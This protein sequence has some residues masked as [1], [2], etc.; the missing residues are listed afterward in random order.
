VAFQNKKNKCPPGGSKL[1]EIRPSKHSLSILLAE[2]SHMD[3]RLMLLMLKTLGYY[4][5]TAATGIEALSALERQAYDL[6]LMDIQMPEMD[7][8]EATKMIRKQ[9]SPGPKIIIVTAFDSECC[10]ELSFDVG[11]DE[12]LNKPVKIDELRDAIERNIGGDLYFAKALC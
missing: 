7:G 12:F 4:A 6:V 10:R 9:W 2:D 3:R 1:I 8:I 5:D 11:A